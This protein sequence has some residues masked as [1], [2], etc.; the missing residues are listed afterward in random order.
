M[1]AV[2]VMG[3]RRR[4]KMAPTLID[5]S[6]VIGIVLALLAMVG[7]LAWLNEESG[8]SLYM[9]PDEPEHNTTDEQ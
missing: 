1:A 2:G 8:R 5:P 6:C 4:S 9:E 7:F 3:E